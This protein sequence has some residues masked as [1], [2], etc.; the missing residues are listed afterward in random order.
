MHAY[1]LICEDVY[2][3]V[4]CERI[5]MNMYNDVQICT[6]TYKLVQIRTNPYQYVQ[7]RTHAYK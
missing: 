1:A 2:K 5:C 4:T 6:N 7:T 3:H